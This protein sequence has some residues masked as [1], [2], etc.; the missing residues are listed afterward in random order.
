M[1]DDGQGCEERNGWYFA[2]AKSKG[3]PEGDDRGDGDGK[4]K[5]R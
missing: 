1:N 5:E 2:A 3:D 4:S